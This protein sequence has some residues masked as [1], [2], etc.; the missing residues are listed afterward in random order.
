LA[1][2]YFHVVIIIFAV[3]SVIIIFIV[4][5]V[6]VIVSIVVVNLLI[7]HYIVTI[8]NNTITFYDDIIKSLAT[9]A[10]ASTHINSDKDHCSCMGGGRGDVII[11]SSISTT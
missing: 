5:I 6:V 8:I 11:S 2:L 1:E 4:S 3:I 9:P 7:V 10:C